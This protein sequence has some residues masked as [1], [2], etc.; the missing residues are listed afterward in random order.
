MDHDLTS[1]DGLE[2]YARRTF[3]SVSFGQPNLIRIDGNWPTLLTFI[4]ARSTTNSRILPDVFEVFVPTRT[5][6]LTEVTGDFHRRSFYYQRGMVAFNP[7]GAQWTIAWDGIVEGVCFYFAP[8]TLERAARTFFGDASA[9]IN[10][11]LAL[12]DN[13]PAIAYLALDIASQ[14]A[15]EFP[16]GRDHANQLLG[17]LLAL[18]VRRYSESKIRNTAQVGIVSPQVLRALQFIRSNLGQPLKLQ[19][20]CDQSASSPAQLNRLFRKELGTSVWNHMVRQRTDQAARMLVA[21]ELPV[22]R[23]AHDCG[24]GSAGNLTRQF[25][26]HK[27]ATPTAFRQTGKDRT[28]TPHIAA[29]KSAIATNPNATELSATP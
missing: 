7:P 4:H 13:A 27:G 9:A 23:I 22:E 15:N 17:A 6:Q 16:A 12:S 8:A 24:F 5:I 20:I 25:V 1:T 2:S 11:R 10:W 3:E 28:N 21:T 26:R 29:S 19:A 18:I 14:A